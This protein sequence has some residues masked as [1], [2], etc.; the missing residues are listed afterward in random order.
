MRTV[1]TDMTHLNTDFILKVFASHEPGIRASGV[2]P[3]LAVIE[4]KGQATMDEIKATL[5][6]SRET[7]NNALLSLERAGFVEV[8]R[9]SGGDKGKLKNIYRIKP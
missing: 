4:S 9:R 1:T 5:G 3:A 6:L 7:T 8:V 2:I